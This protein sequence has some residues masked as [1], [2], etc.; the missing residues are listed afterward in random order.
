MNCLVNSPLIIFFSDTDCPIFACA[1]LRHGYCPHLLYLGR[2]FAAKSNSP[3]VPDVAH[4]GPNHKSLQLIDYSM[5]PF[6]RKSRA[7]LVPQA[8]PGELEPDAV[9]RPHMSLA[10]RAIVLVGDQKRGFCLTAGCL[11][12]MLAYTHS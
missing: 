9:S 8:K 1:R 7:A 3:L 6:L 12:V 11:R 2:R 10:K 4:H 5:Q